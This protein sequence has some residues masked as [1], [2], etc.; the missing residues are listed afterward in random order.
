MPPHKPF[1]C[2]SVESQ[3]PAPALWGNWPGH[4]LGF[5]AHRQEAFGR[6]VTF[7]GEAN[8]EVSPFRWDGTLLGWSCDFGQEMQVTQVLLALVGPAVKWENLGS[9]LVFRPDF[10]C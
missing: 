2:S 9:R 5:S 8:L 3:R 7:T 1:T 4:C 10:F 6:Y